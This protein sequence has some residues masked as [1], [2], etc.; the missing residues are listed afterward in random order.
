MK[1]FKAEIV[2]LNCATNLIKRSPKLEMEFFSKLLY[3][4]FTDGWYHYP[5]WQIPGCFV[6]SVH[7]LLGQ[8]DC[9]GC[10]RSSWLSY[11]LYK[12]EYTTLV[13]KKR[14]LKSDKRCL[15]R[16]A[17]PDDVELRGRWLASPTSCFLLPYLYCSGQLEIFSM[18][19][20]DWW[21][22]TIPWWPDG[23][24]NTCLCLGALWRRKCHLEGFDDH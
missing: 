12:Y 17:W 13:L 22:A 1:L 20:W 11:K 9:H 19:R 23:I 10:L 3:H 8:Q 5:W 16:H 6:H 14:H 7:V 18:E 24:K 21:L 15:H 2:V 4:V